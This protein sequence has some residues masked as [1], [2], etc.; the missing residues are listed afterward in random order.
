M[1]NEEKR[2]EILTAA[3]R[4]MHQEGFE[5]FKMEDIAK[6]AG[7]GKGTIYEYFESKNDLFLE[8][9]RFSTEQFITGL[10]NSLATGT[11]LESKI[12]NLSLF[13]SKFLSS[14]LNLVNSN[15]SHLSLPEDSKD[16][17]KRYWEHI[18]KTIESE[19][20]K[21]IE[22]GEI[23]PHIDLKMA[24]SVIIGS[25]NQYAFKKLYGTGLPPE[26]IDHQAIARM[27]LQG[28]QK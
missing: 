24:A 13:G 6:E 26:Q 22:G 16:Q 5:G 10:E 7:V 21:A 18:Y 1:S 20:A 12:S 17:I 9:L 8:M 28:M 2:L 14:H 23:K 25:L 15:I 19:L 3:M 4:I 11:D 27:I